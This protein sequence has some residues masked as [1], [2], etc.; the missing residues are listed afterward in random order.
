MDDIKKNYTLVEKCWKCI[1]PNLYIDAYNRYKW[2]DDKQFELIYG[3]TRKEAIKERCMYD[4]FCTYWELKSNIK[5]RRFEEN[6]LYLQNKQHELLDNISE[7]EY[8]LFH[9]LGVEKGKRSPYKDDFYRN[10]S[11]YYKPHEECEKLIKMGLMTVRNKLGSYV[12]SVTELGK[13]VVLT[14]LLKTKKELGYDV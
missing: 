5:L 14:T 7:I 12:Y 10:Y 13:E 11:M 6:D 3:R 4:D 9:S 2:L 8:H 1:F